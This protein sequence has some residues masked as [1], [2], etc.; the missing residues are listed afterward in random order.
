[1][2]SWTATPAGW[3]ARATTPSCSAPAASTPTSTGPS[4]GGPRPGCR[5]TGARSAGRRR[6]E[7]TAEGDGAGAA[8][9]GPGSL[10]AGYVF[11]LD[12]T[13]YLGDELLPGAARLLARLRE[14][15]RRGGVVSH[16]PDPRPG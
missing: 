14:L 4:S 5:S 7:V 2:A 11:D 1:R 12:G 10:F 6:P 3:S 8:G 13:V 9:T 15:G 16:K